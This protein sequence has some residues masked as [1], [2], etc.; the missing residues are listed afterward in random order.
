V[1]EDGADDI[2]LR[3]EVSDTGIGMSAEQQA[4]LFQPFVQA[5]ETTTRKFGGTGLGLAITRKIARRMGGDAG[6]ISAPGEGSTFWLTARMGK[7][8][9]P[10]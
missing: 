3:F 7:G 8:L 5:D 6:V 2:L 10:P 4:R 1:E 9:S